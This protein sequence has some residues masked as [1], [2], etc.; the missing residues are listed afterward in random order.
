MLIFCNRTA[1][2]RSE[3]IPEREQGQCSG[4]TPTGYKFQG[5]TPERTPGRPVHA[6]NAQLH[7]MARDS[8][9]GKNHKNIKTTISLK[10]LSEATRV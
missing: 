9:G 8:F 1:S 10:N 3:K 2:E 7:A 6:A 4:Q 5:A